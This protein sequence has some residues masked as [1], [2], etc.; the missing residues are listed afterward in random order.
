M[1]SKLTNIP[2]IIFHPDHCSMLCVSLSI[3]QT[4][5]HSQQMTLCRMYTVQR[6][7]FW[8]D[9]NDY[10][11]MDLSI[12]V[13][14]TLLCFYSRAFTDVQY[15]YDESKMKMVDQSWA[16]GS[17]RPR[18][19]WSRCVR[20]P[21]FKYSRIFLYLYNNS[22]TFSLQYSYLEFL[23]L[24]CRGIDSRIRGTAEETQARTQAILS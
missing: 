11:C 7:I 19:T 24:V 5:L 18:K 12:A 6:H 17:H 3:Y 16:R 8:I 4:T 10:A 23:L 20:V 1:I 2:L 14:A 15:Y 13:W 22:N 21:I 9:L